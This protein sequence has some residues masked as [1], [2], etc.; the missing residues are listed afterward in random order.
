M[1]RR[2]A[3]LA[4]LALVVFGVTCRSVRTAPAA[5]STEPE[6][7]FPDSTP[8]DRAT[9]QGAAS[10]IGE[11]LLWLRTPRADLID[12]ASL[13]NLYRVSPTLLRGAQP[14]KAGFEELEKMGVRT[15]ISLRALHGDEPPAGSKLAYERIS[16]K[17][18]HPEDEDVVRFLQLVN[19]PAKQPVF[20]H[21]RWGS[22]RTGMMCAIYRVACNGWTKDEAL[23]EMTQG[24][25]GFHPEWTNLV[26]YVHKLDIERIATLAGLRAK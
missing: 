8:A 13:T 4:C 7:F 22:D 16:F 12:S 11:K 19:D 17:T 20:V 10:R 14:T 9:S 24:G 3:L 26:D 2:I 6:Q 18:W 5:R 21:C 23:D 15:V 1:L 25:F